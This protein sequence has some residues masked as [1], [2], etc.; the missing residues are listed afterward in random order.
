MKL[1]RLQNLSLIW[2][3][4]IPFL[5]LAA[6]GA[7]ALF[8]VSYRFQSSL[9]HVNEAKRLKNQYQYFLNKIGLK[10]DMAMAGAWLVAKDP[11][12]AE[13]FANKDRERLIE[14]LHP[15]YL[16]LHNRYGITIFHFHLPPAASFLRLH[17]PEQYGE[18]ME[19]YRGTIV[20][21]MNTDTGVGGLERGVF[22][23]AIRSVV[24]INYQGHLIGTVELGMSFEEPFL[25][26]F[27]KNF[28]SDVVLYMEEERGE[29]TPEVF[30]ATTYEGLLPHNFLTRCF[31]TGDTVSYAGSR[32]GRDM[33]VIGGPIRDFSSRIVGVV[34]ISIDRGP[35]LALLKKYGGIAAAVGLAGLFLSISFVWLVSV[36]FTRRIHHVVDAA[37]DI[38][39]GHRDKRIEVT[40]ADELGVMADAINKMLRS[41]EESRRK[42]ND[43]AEN[44]ESMVDERTRALRESEQ[45]YRTLVEHVPLVVYMVTAGGT[46]V[47]L[48]KFLEEMIGVSP[49][50]VSGH[51]EVWAEHI[52][53]SDRDRV[54]QDFNA[55]LAQGKEFHAEY[56]MVHTN[57]CVVHVAD[58]AVPVFDDDGRFIRLDGIVMDVTAHRAL[59]E[60]SIQ[61]E[62]LETLGEVS[63][64]LAHEIRNP[65]TS[66]GGLTRQLLRSFDNSDPRKRKAE[67]IVDEV[68]RLEK[69]L[70][71]LTAYIAPKHI[72]LAC[73][74]LNA[75]V[76]AAVRAIHSKF[77]NSDLS[78]KTNLDGNLPKARL[79]SN[80]LKKVLVNLMENAFYRMKEQGEI[81][82]DTRQNADYV[83]IEMTY[84]VPYISDDDI[85]HFFYPFVV[86]YPFPEDMKDKDMI[87]VPIARIAIHKH[88]GII[89]VKKEGENQVKITISLPK[90]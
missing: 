67:L 75:V 12:V 56:R 27:K 18:E 80:V 14:L 79:D 6:A 49:K 77:R 73:S 15:A 62:E 52:H 45:T 57:G 85:E 37:N 61:A 4:V 69:I 70:H 2:K 13:A 78:V 83:I 7:T 48:N 24:P 43:Y 81:E 54:M 40:G 3:L 19:K 28:G 32:Q 23:Y 88:G 51:H 21:A 87:D 64:R 82:I 31:S 36:I 20:R 65:L 72:R 63:A 26:E 38:A 59:Q 17:A 86:D 76:T 25:D 10:K 35:T 33:A 46:A 53:P 41:L 50:A 5:F 39:A 58:H 29:K 90:D 34:E 11:V 55:C 22:G 30:A 74:D 8:V 44:L 9:I 71:M 89:N 60:K 47:Y 68:G 16:K 1:S 42:I 66:V 84:N